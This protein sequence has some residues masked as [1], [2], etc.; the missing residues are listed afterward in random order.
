MKHLSKV[1]N[2]AISKK[3]KKEFKVAFTRGQ[4]EHRRNNLA[5]YLS[6]DQPV[7]NDNQKYLDSL[8]QKG[9]EDYTRTNAYNLNKGDEWFGTS[10]YDSK[11]KTG[12]NMPTESNWSEDRLQQECFQWAWNNYPQTR[13]CMFHV[14]NERT[15]RSVVEAARYKAIGVVPGAHDMPFFWK[16]RLYIFEFKVGNSTYSDNQKL[17]KEAMTTQGAVCILCRDIEFFK[18]CVE[19]ILAGKPHEFFGSADVYLK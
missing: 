19:C 7:I 3:L 1:A 5:T 10:F 17:F 16:M 11:F 8:I 6:R 15:V 2:K 13:R 14:P 9:P 18:K 4:E 12:I